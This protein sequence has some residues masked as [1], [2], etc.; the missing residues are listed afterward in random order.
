MSAV[1]IIR[2][3]RPT[4]SLSESLRFY[5]DA[6]GFNLIASF[7]DHRGFDGR[8]LSPPSSDPNKPA[9]WHLEF[10]YQRGHEE[11]ESCQAPTKDNLLV[12]YLK[13][14]SEVELKATRMM[15]HGYEP[16]ESLNPYWDDCG[17]TFEDSEGWRIVL[18][19]SEWIL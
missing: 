6:L 2:F 17:I 10:T 13:E 16:V 15:E 18:C 7:D 9:P 12:F 8:I 14:K 3:A 1:P 4:K 11:G 19:W 5:Q